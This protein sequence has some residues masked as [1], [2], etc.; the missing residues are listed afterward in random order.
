MALKFSHFD[1][2]KQMPCLGPAE[3]GSCLLCPGL[4]ARQMA[5]LFLW[6]AN[7]TGPGRSGLHTVSGCLKDLDEI[8][9]EDFKDKESVMV[10]LVYSLTV[11]WWY[12]KNTK[13]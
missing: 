2:L 11:F 6:C 7:I 4:L 10:R 8:H 1:F 13:H 12:S 9:T 3:G 5:P